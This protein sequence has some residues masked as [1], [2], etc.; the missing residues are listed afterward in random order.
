MENATNPKSD[1][2]KVDSESHLT[3]PEFDAAYL[4]AL[5]SGMVPP[6][7]VPGGQ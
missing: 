6:S 4:H 1:V 3:G 7:P 2:A 5:G